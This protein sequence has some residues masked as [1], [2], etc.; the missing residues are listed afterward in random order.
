MALVVSLVKSGLLEIQEY[1]RLQ[2][3]TLRGI[4]SRPFYFRDVV[5]QFEEIGVGSLTVVLL[6]GF[7]TG[8]V[9]ALQSGITLDQFGARP[10]VGRLISASMIKELGP[11]L[12]GLMLAGRVGSGIA[13]ELGSMVVTDQINALRALGTDPVRKLVV[14][15]VLAGF[16]MAPV[17]TVVANTVGIIGGWLIAVY[18]LRVASSLYWTSVI[19]GLVP[20]GRVDGADQAVLP[21]LRHRDDWLSRRPSYDRR[22][23]RRRPRHDQ[24]RGRL[25]CR[26]DRRRL[27]CDQTLDYGVVLVVGSMTG[28]TPRSAALD[29]ALGPGSPIVMLD[30]VSLAFDE[31]VILRNISFTLLTGHTKIILGAS[32]SGKSTILKLILGLLKPDEGVVWVNGERVDE[33]T[34]WELMKVRADLGMVFQEG[35]LFDSLTVAENVGYKL[36]EESDMPAAD[37]RRRVDEILGFIGLGEFV[38]RKPSELSGGQRRRVAIARAMASKPRLLLYD[39][40]TTGLD[41][42]T[43]I[44]VDDEIIKLRDI[45]NVSSILVTH[46]LR[47]AF[48]VA[49]HEAVQPRR[50][51]VA[52]RAGRSGE[53]RGSGVHHA[54]RRQHRV[55]RSRRGAS[56]VVRPVS[57]DFLVVDVARVHRSPAVL[58]R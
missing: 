24:C 12:T 40:P 23:S 16:F 38:D 21:W 9:L 3:Q 4:F 41:P 45:E 10:F 47:D 2:G 53:V 44:T 56:S 52:N 15:R 37:V 14:P 34:E 1:M 29:E 6:T 28:A 19:E 39:E 7:F 55:R 8:A 5:E 11:V 32:G 54:E 57:E 36:Y 20:R 27:L 26:R 49:T 42:I 13:A 58:D 17:L 25:V 18:Q 50:W 51:A 46:Q 30:K 35:A 43:A 22:H 31:K 48:F 33:M